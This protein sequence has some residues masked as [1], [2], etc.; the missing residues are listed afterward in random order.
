M[1][2]RVNL[3]FLVSPERSPIHFCQCSHQ[4][5]ACLV[6][7]SSQALGSAT[8]SLLVEKRAFGLPGGLRMLWMWP[9]LDNTNSHLPP[10]RSAER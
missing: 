6:A 3:A 2:P 1:L 7:F 10:S 5:S 8:I 9:L 4:E